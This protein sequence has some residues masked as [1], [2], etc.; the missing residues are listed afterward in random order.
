M[1]RKLKNPSEMEHGF[2]LV[3]MMIAIV[4]LLVGIVAVAKLVPISTGSNSQNRYN[5]AAVVAAQRELDGLLDQSISL[6]TFSDPQGVLC[7]IGIACQLGNPA[8]PGAVLGSPVVMYGVRPVIDYTQAQVNG[9]GF[10]YIDPNDPSG[11]YDIR[12]AVIVFAN[13]GGSASAKRFIVGAKPIGGN[14]PPVP[15]TFDAMVD[16]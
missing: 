3:E 5:S 11:G 9:Y 14:R 16:K 8:T 1:S 10:N 13:G 15:V 6:T 4:V 2:A 7:P 12:W